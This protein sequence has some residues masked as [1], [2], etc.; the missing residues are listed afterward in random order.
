MKKILAG[1][2][3]VALAALPMAGVFAQD[4]NVTDTLQITV[5]SAC[6]ITEGSTTDGLDNK[7]TTYAATVANGAEADFSSTHTGTHAFH[8]NCNS[9]GGWSFSATPQNLTGY[10]AANDSTTNG[11]NI[12]FVASGSY[13]ASG[14]TG[15]WTAEIT[16]PSGIT[17]TQPSTA[18][19]ANTVIN[20]TNAQAANVEITS[21]Y[22]AYV[23]TQT[24]AGYY[25]GT[26][27]YTLAAL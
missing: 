8:V 22:H 23:G 9:Q 25:E 14:A 6:T 21:E 16:A 27:A 2:G 20:A 13:E 12:N 10:V 26:I 3:A 15:M 24:T 1:A 18:G 17:V 11:D 19:T 5:N 4:L 7:D